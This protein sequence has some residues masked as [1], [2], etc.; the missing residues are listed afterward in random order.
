MPDKTTPGRVVAVEVRSVYGNELIYPVNEP[1][2]IF[3][4]LT[5]NKTLNLVDLQRIQS[6]GFEVAEVHSRKLPL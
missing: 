1:A 4:S 6:L 2:K 3:A 5:G